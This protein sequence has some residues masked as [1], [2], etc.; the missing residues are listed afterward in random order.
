M[1]LTVCLLASALIV[2]SVVRG[3]PPDRECP[4]APAAQNSPSGASGKVFSKFCEATSCPETAS[5]C[6]CAKNAA[7]VVEETKAK[8]YVNTTAATEAASPCCSKKA[9]SAACPDAQAKC[10]AQAKVASSCSETQAE[11]C[12]QARVATG[13]D[14][15]AKSNSESTCSTLAAGD[16]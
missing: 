6:Q 9:I 4:D 11:C 13:V 5:K 16:G 10:C 3:N 8:R 7:K 14:T 12:K 1:R 15:C 2:S